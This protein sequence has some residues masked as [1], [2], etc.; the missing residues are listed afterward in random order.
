MVEGKAAPDAAAP[1][2][3]AGGPV[4]APWS[5]CISMPLPNAV[6]TLEAS[7]G[8]KR[9]M[10]YGGLIAWAIYIAIALLVVSF[11][12][13][14][15]SN[16]ITQS[17]VKTE[18]EAWDVKFLALKDKFKPEERIEAL[19]KIWDQVADTPVHPYVMLELAQ[20]HFG[21]AATEDRS[22]AA[23]KKSLERARALF[24]LLQTG[25]AKQILYGALSADGMAACREQEG[26]LDGAIQTLTMAVDKYEEH[27]LY[28]KFCFQ[29]G[30][31]Y[32]LRAL[33]QEAAG[34]DGARDRTEAKRWL[35]AA[36][37]ETAD[38][39]S[40][41]SIWRS[42]AAMLKSQLDKH[43]VA[44]PAQAP[45]PVKPAPVPPAAQPKEGG[46]NKAE[47]PLP[48]AENKPVAPL[49][50]PEKSA[51][52]KPAGAEKPAPAPPPAPSPIQP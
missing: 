1:S 10:A 11:V 40:H 18:R 38:S 15:V 2:P 24:E 4:C 20:L 5:L 44:W 46:E 14:I 17:R 26:D 25:Y 28:P 3:A 22:P 37:T 33:K 16:K 41:G 34:K 39:A 27:F 51:E 45:P 36:S 52:K 23:R 48:G 32:W 21:Q 43:G 42:K 9:I 29:L 49:P 6:H 12:F 31:N 50:A 35:T 30:R 47:A 7:E 13:L 8:Q 19:E